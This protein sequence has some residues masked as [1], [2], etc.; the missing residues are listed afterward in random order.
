MTVLFVSWLLR[1]IP[2]V[3]MMTVVGP[4]VICATICCLLSFASCPNSII[5]IVLLGGRVLCFAIIALLPRGRPRR[6]RLLPIEVHRAGFPFCFLVQSQM[7]DRP[8]S[9]PIE[10]WIASFQWQRRRW[11]RGHKCQQKRQR[12]RTKDSPLIWAGSD[13][14]GLRKRRSL[15]GCFGK[16]RGK[17]W[18]RTGRGC[19]GRPDSNSSTSHRPIPSCC[20]TKLLRLKRGLWL[21]NGS[22]LARRRTNQVVRSF[23]SGT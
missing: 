15:R 18:L 5:S 11:Q 7:A 10:T 1:T 22:S 16:W 12:S 19:V 4:L 21:R 20:S 17:V 14:E 2:N 13:R 3:L 6:V 9:P 8:N 23:A